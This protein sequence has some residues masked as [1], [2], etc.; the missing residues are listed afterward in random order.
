MKR[1]VR[2]T[3]VLVAFVAAGAAVY[4]AAFLIAAVVR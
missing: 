1:F 3:V 2:N 4:G